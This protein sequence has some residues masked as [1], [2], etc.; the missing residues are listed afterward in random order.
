MNRPPTPVPDSTTLEP[1]DK[2][3]MPIITR[4]SCCRILNNHRRK[5]RQ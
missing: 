4:R 5:R 2:I 3:N 1:M